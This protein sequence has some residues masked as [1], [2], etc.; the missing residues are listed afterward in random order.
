MK[1]RTVVKFLYFSLIMLSLGCGKKAASEKEVIY[2]GYKEPVQADESMN[3]LELNMLTAKLNNSAIELAW[4]P[5]LGVA[6]YVIF[7][8]TLF[9]SI[10]EDCNIVSDSLLTATSE[11]SYSYNYPES[12]AGKTF[13]Y[14]VCTTT[15]K[16][17]EASAIGSL[18]L[19][20][21]EESEKIYFWANVPEEDE[22]VAHADFCAKHDAFAAP[23]QGY[24]ICA[25]GERR[26]RFGEGYASIDYRE[27]TWGSSEEGS[28]GVK[29]VIGDSDMYYCYNEGSKTDFDDTDVLV[30]WLCVK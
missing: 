5:I 29:P 15:S 2:V 13:Y 27:G 8:S 20:Q 12:V 6:H 22:E 25:A 14:K 4:E 1:L 3:S 24:G 9:S 17:I 23:N 18:N 26:P 30:A 10:P 11:F 16:G 19:P 21:A 7:G 28:G